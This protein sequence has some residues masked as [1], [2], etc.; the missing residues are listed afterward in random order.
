MI[1]YWFE[2]I[3]MDTV[4]GYNENVYLNY[5]LYILLIYD[6]HYY[7]N[8]KMMKSASLRFVQQ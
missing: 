8:F 1:G 3:N 4:V 7:L 5:L 6:R 2:I